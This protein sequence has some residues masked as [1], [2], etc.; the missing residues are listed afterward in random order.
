MEHQPDLTI[1]NA[2]LLDEP[3]AGPVLRKVTL[4]L[5]PFIFL[6]FVLNILDRVNVG[7]ARL[8][9]LEQLHLSEEV[10][11]LGSSIFFLGY[12][13]FQLPSNLILNRIGARLWIAGIVVTWGLISS[14]MMF[15]RDE[16]SFY[17]LRFLLGV[18]ESGFFPGM[19]LY[20]TYW[21]PSRERA[22]AT[23]CFMTAS[24][25]SGIVGSPI[26]GALMTYLDQTAG[27]A[28]WQWMFLLEGLPTVVMGIVVIFWLT[29]RPEVA[30]WLQPEERTWLSQRMQLEQQQ[31]VQQHGF[32]LSQTL[33]NGRVWL[34]CGLYFALAMGTNG[35]ALYLP[36]L[37]RNKFTGADKFQI[38]LL[39]AIP[40]ILAVVCMVL[41]SIHSDRT[42]ERRWHVAV[43]AF[44]AAI[45]WG[46]AA[47][48]D[49]PRMSLAA[50]A[51]ASLGMY[52][53][54]APFWSLPNSF[55]TGAAAA[56][57]I[58]LI[59]S[60]GNLG[61]FVAPLM[62]S[63]VKTLSGSFSGGLLAMAVTLLIAGF[64]ALSVRH[65]QSW[66]R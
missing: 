51:L 25:V 12:F 59:N 38:G 13:L 56:G 8:Q 66:E 45:G 46:F 35:F 54:F 15:I 32:T 26:S 16:F 20:L 4:R 39:S 24:A 63:R 37:V 22:K 52:S 42:G 31:R 64:L 10:Y 19:I 61:G 2:P 60:V 50:L 5:I 33:M 7:F 18:A 40:Y 58:A 1:V 34:L 29:D 49:D 53:T 23:A 3:L 44:L 36:E 28:G 6:L 57:G 41:T 14:A 9:M 21:I 17:T 47:Y 55:L 30:R 48:L 62:I 65:E 27:L 43:P 11:G